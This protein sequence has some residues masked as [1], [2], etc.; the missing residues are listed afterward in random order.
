[1]N[2]I[3]IIIFSYN[4]PSGFMKHDT[5][6]SLRNTSGSGYPFDLLSIGFG[7]PLFLLSNIVFLLMIHSPLYPGALLQT[8]STIRESKSAKNSE[9]ILSSLNELQQAVV[10][11]CTMDLK[12]LE[13]A[14]K[15]LDEQPQGH[16]SQAD[17]DEN[18]GHENVGRWVYEYE[19]RMYELQ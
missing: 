12:P 5:L 15:K 1:M 11:V 7:H 19:R 10:E 18:A 16:Q 17:H 6:V 3:I 2:F 9:I 13:N 4:F 8:E 14:R